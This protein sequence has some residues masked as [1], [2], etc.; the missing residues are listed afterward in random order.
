[1][2]ERAQKIIG[3]GR[4]KGF[5]DINPMWRIRQLTEVFGPSGQG[6]YTRDVQY[7][8]E[9]YGDERAVFCSLNLYCRDGD[10]WSSPVYGIGGSRVVSLDKNGMYLDDE[11]YKKAYTDA[12]SVACKALGM[13]ADIYFDKDKVSGNSTKY[14]EIPRG[15]ERKAAT[16][17]TESPK[18]EGEPVWDQLKMYAN[19]VKRCAMGLNSRNGSDYRSEYIRLAKPDKDEL[20]R[21]DNDVAEYRRKNNI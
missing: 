10:G 19:V 6:W 15:S 20:E 9:G 7:W 16:V 21:F 13:A 14:D 4:L 18:A 5:T 17:K 8:T 11:A 1:M 2:P 3:G 12:L